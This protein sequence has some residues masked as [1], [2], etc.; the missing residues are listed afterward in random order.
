MEVIT[1]ILLFTVGLLGY[2]VNSNNTEILKLKNSSREKDYETQYLL[3]E[4]EK[5]I[6]NLKRQFQTEKTKLLQA[7]NINGNEILKLKNEI[8]NLKNKLNEK[9]NNIRTLNE[10]LSS[11]QHKNENFRDDNENLK[12][13]ILRLNEQFR[14]KSDRIQTL[15]KMLT[16]TQAENDELKLK[17]NNLENGTLPGIN[18]PPPPHPPQPKRFVQVVFPGYSQDKYD[19]LLGDND[20]VEVGDFVMVGTKG[21]ARKAK[22]VRV[23]GYGE[24]SKKAKSKIIKKL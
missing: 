16:A 10:T 11:V 13:E 18:W 7:P 22:V 4:K 24:I 17:I 8:A 23:S 1:T 19:Y 9:E 21:G 15:D 5:E 2:L 12:N 14:E 6:S 3:D 20:D